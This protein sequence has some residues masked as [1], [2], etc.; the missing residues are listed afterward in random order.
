MNP[1]SDT[2]QAL[3]QKRDELYRDARANPDSEAGEMVQMLLLAGLSNMRPELSDEEAPL[4]LEEERRRYQ[5]ARHAQEAAAGAARLKAQDDALSR[6]LGE[7]QKKLE[8]AT[9]V[10]GLTELQVYNRIAEIIGLRSP[11]DDNADRDGG[12]GAEE[13]DEPSKD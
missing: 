3:R 11:A 4:T 1:H 8:R 10:P 2:L 12:T 9:A 5:L 7:G 13:P 6:E